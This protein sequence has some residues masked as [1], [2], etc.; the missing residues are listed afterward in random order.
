MGRVRLQIDDPALRVTLAAILRNGGHEIADT[1]ADVVIAGQAEEAIEAAR[2]GP[3]LLI[4]TAGDIPEAV[5]AMRQGVYGYIFLPLQPGETDIMVQRAISGGAAKEE[6]ELLP[7]S[8]VEQRH[9]EMVLRHCRHNRSEAARILGIGRN[10][11]W[12][13]LRK[14]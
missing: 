1:D 10:T 7:L 3:A 14:S 11:L 4:A 6:P 2:N 13:K 8:E 5:R 9:I 12:R